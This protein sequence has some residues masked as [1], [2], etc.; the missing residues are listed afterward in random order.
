[1]KTRMKVKNEKKKEILILS[2]AAKILKM[3]PETLRR[4]AK[5]GEAPAYKS[6]KNWIFIYEDLISYVCSQYKVENNFYLTNSKLKGDKTCRS[7][8][9]KALHLPHR[10]YMSQRKIQKEYDKL[11]V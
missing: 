10:G 3:S 9:T 5:E 6:G 8:K 1:M 2:E 11:M 4:K 7:T